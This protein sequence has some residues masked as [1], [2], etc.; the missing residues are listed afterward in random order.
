MRRYFESPTSRCVSHSSGSG[1]DLLVR[2][3]R[4]SIAGT[5]RT[6]YE[7]RFAVLRPKHLTGC[8]MT[9][10]CNCTPRAMWKLSWFLRDFGYDI[11]LLGK[12]EI[13]DK[14]LVD[15]WGGSGQRSH[16]A[17]YLDPQLRRLCSGGPLEELSA[18]TDSDPRG[19]EVS[20]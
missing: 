13:D 2:V 17:W 3:D 16:G 8:F 9:G 15:L 18:F 14:A 12:N 10:R 5:S 11:E 4:P 6:L 1:R 20:S 7:I 19:S